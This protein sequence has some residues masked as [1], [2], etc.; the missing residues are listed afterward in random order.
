MPSISSPRNRSI[1]DENMNRAKP[2]L[3]KIEISIIGLS[4]LYA[5]PNNSSRCI[6]Q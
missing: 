2:A 3:E 4:V 5:D 6:E 1:T